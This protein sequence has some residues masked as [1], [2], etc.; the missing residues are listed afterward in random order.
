LTGRVHARESPPVMFGMSVSAP[1][2]QTFQGGNAS[3]A[4]N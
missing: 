3:P 2:G 4:K 1:A